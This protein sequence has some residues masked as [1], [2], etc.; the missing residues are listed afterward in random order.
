MPFEL[1]IVGFLALVVPMCWVG[2]IRSKRR[3]AV[4]PW[5]AGWVL[6]L[7]VVGF[8]TLLG[9]ATDWTMPGSVVGMAWVHPGGIWISPARLASGGAVLAMATAQI[10]FILTRSRGA[11]ALMMERRTLSAVIETA[12]IGILVEGPDHRIELVNRTG[13]EHILCGGT[14]ADWLGRTFFE[15]SDALLP[16]IYD[17]KAKQQIIEQATRAGRVVKDLE[18]VLHEPEERIVTLCASP[19]SSND[20]EKLGRVWLSRDV[21]EERRLGEQ[22]RHSQKLETIGT[23]SGGIAHDFNNQLAVILGNVR[24]AQGR[25]SGDDEDTLELRESLSDL[26]RAADHCAGLT[27][28]LLAFARRSPVRIQCLEAEHVMGELE[29]LLRPLIPSSIEIEVEVAP[30]LAPVAADPTQ[31]QQV[32]LNLAVNA[33]DAMKDRGLLE[34][35]VVARSMDEA[36]ARDV[37]GARPGQFIEISVS[38]TGAGLDPESLTRIFEPFYTTKPVGEGTGLGLAIVHGVVSAHRGWI[39]VQSVPGRGTTFRVLLP[40]ASETVADRRPP[41]ESSAAAGGETILVVDDEPAIR[42][43]A[44]LELERCGFRVLEAEDGDRAMEIFE[45]HREE[46]DLVFLDMTMPGMDGLEVRSAVLEQCP[47]MRV[48]LTSGHSPTELS[49]LGAERPPFLHK[50]YAMAELSGRIRSVLDA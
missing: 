26:E 28:S 41:G 8:E 49:V 1:V 30:G 11:R 16:R 38:D 18:I 45:Q 40:V 31:I 37:L 12:P 33:R 44:R 39:E 48:I 21:T 9:A 6:V 46:I 34:I 27:R 25:I 42:R 22:L 3:P 47:A 13:V 24:Y 17:A 23:L 2:L 19:V 4:G 32:I 5:L 10:S 15:M 36:A 7:G 35:R 43:L 50:P 14:P 20:G 29:E